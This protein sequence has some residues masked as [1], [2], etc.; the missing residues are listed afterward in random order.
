MRLGRVI[1]YTRKTDEMVA[2]YRDHFGYRVLP[3]DPGDR[4]V[5]LRPADGGAALLL[6][7]AGK[8][9]RQGQ[10][11]V[12]LVFDVA[13]VVASRAAL[14]EAGLAVGPVHDAGGYGFANLKDPSGNPVQISG[15]AYWQD[16]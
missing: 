5:E 14:I 2:F 10:A 3:S 1:V 7:P 8:G 12:K 13:D 15:R 11:L 16:G 4:I 9:Q 6:H